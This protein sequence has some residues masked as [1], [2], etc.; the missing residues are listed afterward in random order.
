MPGP[1]NPIKI[2]ELSKQHTEDEFDDYNQLEREI[3]ILIVKWTDPIYPEGRDPHTRT[4]INA[5]NVNK[6]DAM[7]NHA[8]NRR[9]LPKLIEEEFRRITTSLFAIIETID[10]PKDPIWETNPHPYS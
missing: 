1:N 3:L 4:P 8:G 6:L 2:M 9:R 5:D 10:D 7:L